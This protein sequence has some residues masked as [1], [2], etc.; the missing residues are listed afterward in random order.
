MKQEMVPEYFRA[1]RSKR[2]GWWL[3]L[4]DKDLRAMGVAT[5]SFQPLT[6][7]SM[8]DVEREARKR[9]LKPFPGG[10]SQ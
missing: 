6:F 5:K 10:P 2:E 8:S 3:E 9:G 7:E 1:I 4:I